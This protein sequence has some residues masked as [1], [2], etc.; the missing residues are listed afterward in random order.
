MGPT[1]VAE[2]RFLETG[3]DKLLFV[4]GVRSTLRAGIGRNYSRAFF[5]HTSEHGQHP[6]H[7]GYLCREVREFVKLAG[8]HFLFNGYVQVSDALTL[9]G[10]LVVDVLASLFLDT[11]N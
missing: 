8:E 5:I 10:Y 1:Q 6:S 3:R 11:G 2:I 4:G 7:T 9:I